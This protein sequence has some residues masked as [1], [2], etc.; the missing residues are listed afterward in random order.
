MTKTIAYV[1]SYF[2]FHASLVISLAIIGDS[3]SLELPK[4]REELNAAQHIFRTVFV[5]NELAARCADTLDVIVPEQFATG[6]D[7]LNMPLDPAFIDFSTWSESAN[8]FFGMLGWSDF[9][10]M[11]E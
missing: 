7:W 9:D 6:D 2:T 11:P 3:E 10:Y 1:S 4:R 8:D 5:G